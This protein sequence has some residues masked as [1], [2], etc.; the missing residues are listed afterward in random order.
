MFAAI[1]RS[2]I[3][4][5]WRTVAVWVVAA[6]LL[7]VLSPKLSTYTTSNQQSFLP[8]S[9]ESVKAQNVGNKYFPAQSGGTGSIVISRNDGGQLTSSDQQKVQGLVSTLNSDKLTGVTT[10]QLSQSSLAQNGKVMAAQ[11]VFNGQPGADNVNT[12]VNLVRSK[13]DAYLAGSGL[14]NGLTGN[15]AISV[16]TTNAYNH[17]ETIITIATVLL[18]VVLLGAIFRSPLISVLPIIVIGIVHAAAVGLTAD[19]AAAFGFQVSNSVAPILVVVLFGVGTDYIVFLLFRYRERL[20]HGASH[21]E[22]L[23]FASSKV[24]VVIA[25]SAL[26]VIGAFAALLLA[27]LGS[28]QTLGPALIAAV[29]LMLITGLTLVPALFILLDRHLF[30]PFG[31]GKASEGGVFVREGRF[32]ASHPGVVAAVV[33]V[34]LGGL[35]VGATGYD[36]TCNTLAELPSDTPSQVAYNTLSTAFPAGALSPTQVYV[37]GSQKLSQSNLQPMVADLT[38]AKGVA[39][40]GQPTLSSDGTAALTNVILK[41]NPYSNAALD[42]V[43]G[44]VRSAAHGSV[45]GSQVLVGGQTS[46][47]VDVRQQLRSD[48]RLVFPVAGAIIIVILALLLQALVAPVN[49][50]VCVGLAFAATLGACVI[51]FLDIG[52]FSGIDFSLPMTLYL[53][54]VAI[55]T[56]YN[57]LMSSRLREEFMNGFSPKEATRIAISND[58]PTV[59]AAGVILAL[60]FASLM[61]AGLD[62]LLELG[63]GVGLGIVMA[64]F[65][66]APVLIPSLSTIEGHMF[67]WPRHAR[68][69]GPR[70]R[71]ATPAAAAAL[72]GAGTSGEAPGQRSQT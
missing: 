19:L 65:L 55:G 3:A 13:T 70:E 54:V 71:E 5:P 45:P 72:A 41:D 17:A 4:H 64:A 20:R 53:F 61:L 27:K 25:S 57:I 9:F 29:G 26:T 38:K 23:R 66:M 56:D 14:K 32:V 47:L 7:I 33:E 35:A 67:W 46:Q 22:A 28:L 1:A 60:T 43:K 63:F 8:N 48:T 68:P 58:A 39:Q 15:A 6:V 24:G 36:P 30:W 62:N 40:V 44:P 34:V 16:D 21:H 50:L 10:V 11:V 59:A 69:D 31:P 37:S 18:I 51:V 52:S 12:G 42:N 49:L 2:V